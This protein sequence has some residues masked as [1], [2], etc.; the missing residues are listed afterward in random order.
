MTDSMT[1]AIDETNRRRQV[2]RQYNEA[3]GITPA[4]ITKPVDMSLAQDRRR[5]LSAD[6]SRD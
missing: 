5:G 3:N 6:S 1:R 2:Q 4:S